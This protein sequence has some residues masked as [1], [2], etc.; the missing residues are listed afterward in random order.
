MFIKLS[1]RYMVLEAGVF[2]RKQ[3]FLLRA[4][5]DSEDRVTSINRNAWCWKKTF[6]SLKQIKCGSWWQEKHRRGYSLQLG[7]LGT[8][9]HRS[10]IQT[11]P[12]RLTSGNLQITLGIHRSLPLLFQTELEKARNL[13]RLSFSRSLIKQR[14]WCGMAYTGREFPQVPFTL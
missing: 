6:P 4:C 8:C 1:H 14:W 9:L 10:H 5:L 12:L 13:V 11:Y 3:E 2:C 7:I